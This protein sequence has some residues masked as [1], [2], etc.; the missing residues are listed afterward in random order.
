MEE[1]KTTFDTAKLALKK[2][3]V[4]Q[5]RD[6]YLDEEFRESWDLYL[7][8][9]YVKR[10]KSQNGFGL[11]TQTLLQKWLREVHNI[12]VV[13]L[14]YTTSVDGVEPVYIWMIYK[15]VASTKE[16]KPYK[17]YEN[18]LEEG[19]KEALNLLPDVKQK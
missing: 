17:S 15:L 1:Q 8:D 12:I 14:P 6:G 13:A 16:N 10:L 9:H 5:C 4:E 3:F 18:A 11:P 7:S 2:G 19:L